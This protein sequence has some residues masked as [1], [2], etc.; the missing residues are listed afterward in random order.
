MIT[1]DKTTQAE[2]I[3]RKNVLW[4][5]GAGLIPLPIIDFVALTAVQL[6]MLKQ[7]SNLYGQD[8]S[9]M[10]GKAFIGAV[11]GSVLSRYG[12]SMLKRLPG[13]G[14]ILGG[15]T[16]AVSAGAITYAMGQVFV[17]YLSEGKDL[18]NVDTSEAKEVFEEELKKGEDAAG[19]MKKDDKNN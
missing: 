6:D 10:S 13:I 15:L 14:F 17:K 16:M 7:L 4:S 1:Q 11:G 12:S 5:A 8:Y 2:A 18:A 19:D 9:E 3:I